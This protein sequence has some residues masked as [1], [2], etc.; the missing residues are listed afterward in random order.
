[1]GKIGFLI[2]HDYLDRLRQAGQPAARAREPPGPAGLASWAGLAGP[3]G[4]AGWDSQ[5]S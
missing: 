1:M 3:A 2:E 5:F 4:L